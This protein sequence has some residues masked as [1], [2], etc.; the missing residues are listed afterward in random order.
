MPYRSKPGIRPKKKNRPN[1]PYSAFPLEVT[2][3]TLSKSRL[4][5]GITRD[6]KILEIGSGSGRLANYLTRKF[7]IDP[8]NYWLTD[9]SYGKK[10]TW[11]IKG[12]LHRLRRKGLRKQYLDYLH[13]SLPR[14][15]KFDKIIANEVL[16]SVV[17]NQLPEEKVILRLPSH[18]LAMQA[19]SLKI[20][21]ENFFPHLKVG[22]ELFA[23]SIWIMALEESPYGRRLK[24]KL[25]NWRKR[26]IIEYDIPYP[27]TGVISRFY[28][29]RLQ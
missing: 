4:E 11:A 29:K 28:L 24:A 15:A 18:Y 3:E 12:R 8:T 20:L 5:H 25:E 22:G 7:K 23:S 17:R 27:S 13:P 2:L 10:E 21:V 14:N 26:G 1:L 6:S 19:Q 16:G 9:A